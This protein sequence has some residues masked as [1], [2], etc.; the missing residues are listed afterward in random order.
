MPT[1]SIRPPSR[2]VAFFLTTFLNRPNTAPGLEATCRN[3]KVH[4]VAPEGITESDIKKIVQAF[5]DETDDQFS[6]P[7]QIAEAR[8]TANRLPSYMT[9]E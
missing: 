8:E 5:A 6:T 1:F 7:D 2:E 9:W 4:I 3:G